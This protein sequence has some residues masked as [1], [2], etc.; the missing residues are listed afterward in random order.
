MATYWHGARPH[1]EHCKRAF[2][3]RCLQLHPHGL[4]PGLLAQFV[5]SAIFLSWL[6]EMV[7][8]VGDGGGVVEIGVIGR[9]CL[10]VFRGPDSSVASTGRHA[11]A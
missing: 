2:L 1:L 7:H 10:E 11:L 9:V 6:A 4:C 3:Q 5:R 8:R